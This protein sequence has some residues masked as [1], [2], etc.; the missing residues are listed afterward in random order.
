MSAAASAVTVAARVART[1]AA[2]RV[3]PRVA[4]VRASRAAVRRRAASRAARNAATGIVKAVVTA[5]AVRSR[6]REPREPREPREAQRPREP[7]ERDHAPVVEAGA[8]ETGA[9]EPMLENGVPMQPAAGADA[10]EGG[11]RRRRGRRGRGGDRA[12]RPGEG[13]AQDSNG[14]VAPNVVD[15]V[16]MGADAAP[17]EGPVREARPPKPPREPRAPREQREPREPRERRETAAAPE[18]NALAIDQPMQNVLPIETAQPRAEP[19]ADF[20]APQPAPAHVA[21]EPAPVAMTQA[22]AREVHAEPARKV[23]PAIDIPPI[24][25]TLPPDSGL[26][27]VETSHAA[28]PPMEPEAPRPKRQRPPKLEIAAEPLEFVETRKEPPSPAA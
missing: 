21:L 26:V 17:A 12:D 1:T 11:S 9:V 27:L 25:L 18:Q 3:A 14:D 13:E 6:R 7:K 28:P 8:L 15:A 5:T 23:A 19:V 22:P 24:A 20:V 16:G 2:R 10:R 4:A